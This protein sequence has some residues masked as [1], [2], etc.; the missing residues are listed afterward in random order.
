M[1]KQRSLVIA[2]AAFLLISCGYVAVESE[3]PISGDGYHQQQLTRLPF[4]VLLWNIHKENDNALWQQEYLQLQQ[5]L[6]PDF[7][8]LQEL[9]YKPQTTA[10]FTEKHQGFEYLANLYITESKSYSGVG[11]IARV[12]PDYHRAHLTRAKEPITNSAKPTLITRYPIT[13]SEHSLLLINLHGI[14]F[15]LSID[16]YKQ[17]LEVIA[18]E[19]KQHTGAVIV[20]G[21]FNSWSE[22]R[23]DYLVT[24]MANMGLQAVDFGQQSSHIKSFLGQRLDHIYYSREWLAVKADS[25]RVITGLQSSDHSPLYVTFEWRH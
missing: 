16:G 14:N 8:L 15:Q 23:S 17:Q 21:D 24:L 19:V 9:V 3:Q 6:Q 2:A 25:P 18:D 20:A 13:D 7:I 11:S 1:T 5:Q 12:K 4:R 10:N 22:Q